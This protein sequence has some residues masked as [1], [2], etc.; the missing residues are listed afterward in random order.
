MPNIPLGDALGIDV[1]G[2]LKKDAKLLKIMPLFAN[3]KD[4]RLDQFPIA[5][6]HAGLVFNEPLPVDVGGL[7]LKVG[8]GAGGIFAIIGPQQKPLDPDDPFQAIVV[9]PDE[10]YVALG[11]NFSL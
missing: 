5:Q 7:S 8:A 6:A 1:D 4:I 11:L 9:K 2:K 3:I 10:L